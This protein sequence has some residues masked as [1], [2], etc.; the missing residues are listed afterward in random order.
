MIIFNFYIQKINYNIKRL[1]IKEITV[2]YIFLCLH[3]YNII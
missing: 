2:H 1:C 3:D